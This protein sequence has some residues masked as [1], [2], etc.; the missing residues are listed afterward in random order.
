MPGGGAVNASTLLNGSSPTVTSTRWTRRSFRR[1]AAVELDVLADQMTQQ[2]SPPSALGPPASDHDRRASRRWSGQNVDVAVCPAAQTQRLLSCL[3]SQSQHT[4]EERASRTGRLG[5]KSLQVHA[6]LH[7]VR[8]RSDMHALGMRGRWQRAHR[9]AGVCDM[10]TLARFWR[11]SKA[12]AEAVHADGSLTCPFAWHRLHLPAG[13]T[14]P[15]LLC[16]WTGKKELGERG[17]LLKPCI[18]PLLRASL[19][20]VLFVPGRNAVR[21]TSLVARLRRGER[22]DGIMC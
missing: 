21:R 14:A 15:F 19:E 11:F 3:T 22:S 12:H 8:P 4:C 20:P 16:L 9:C 10:D 5:A 1:R 7:S 2:A 18:P 17:W 6:L 13:I